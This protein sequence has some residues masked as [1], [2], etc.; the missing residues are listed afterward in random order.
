MG[1][2]NLLGL[3]VVRDDF[4]AIGD[5]IAGDFRGIWYHVLHRKPPPPSHYMPVKLRAE[6]IER[7]GHQCRYCG[8]HG[9]ETHG[10]DGKAWHVDHVWPLKLGG[11][12]KASNLA[13]ACEPCNL[14]KGDRVAFPEY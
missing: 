14:Q 12:S 13:L 2:A 11:Q 10:P 3:D 6:I 1:I 7:D 4:A 8:Q 5:G 9:T